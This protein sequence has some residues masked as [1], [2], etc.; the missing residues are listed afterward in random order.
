MAKL[1]MVAPN[2]SPKYTNLLQNEYASLPQ[3]E[4]QK[5]IYNARK[6]VYELD[7]LLWKKQRQHWTG[8]EDP[9]SSDYVQYTVT[10]SEAGS[11]AVADEVTR[12]LLNRDLHTFK[13]KYELWCEKRG[14]PVPLKKEGN[15][16][17]LFEGG[18][19]FEDICIQALEKKLNKE[20]PEHLWEVVP[21][22]RM[23]QYGERDADGNLVA[24]WL[25]ATPDGFVYCD[26]ELEGIAEFKNIQQFSPNAKVVKQKIVPAEYYVQGSHYMIA[27][28]TRRIFYMIAMGNNYPGD[29]HMLIENRDEAFCEELF[30]VEKEY[31]ESLEK[32][33]EPPTDG[34]DGQSV[35][36]LHEF[37]R[38]KCGN[39]VPDA[40][41]VELNEDLKEVIEELSFIEADIADLEEQIAKLKEDRQRLLVTYILPKA[42]NANEVRI[43]REDSN[44]YFQVVLKDKKPKLSVN[45]EEIKIREPEVY[46]KCLEKKF[47][48]ELFKKHYPELYKQYAK[49]SETL[50]DAKKEYVKIRI[51]ERK[52]E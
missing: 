47:S 8:Y 30:R 5:Y 3:K 40:P 11:I 50:T 13:C 45:P 37:L 7:E 23:Y 28:A 6:R 16:A 39:F 42:G 21:G 52:E 32:G 38:R 22:D 29:F 15:S 1:M 36:Q 26:G 2:K 43:P 31:V 35:K 34:S 14:I 48:T 27:T 33:I 24:P 25:I 10:G 17:D 18:H 46:E 12:K 51:G 44:S 20:Y 41:P 4:Q 9:S 19:L 49:P